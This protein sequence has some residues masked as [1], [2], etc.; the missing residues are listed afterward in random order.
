MWKKTACLVGSL[1]LSL[2]GNVPLTGLYPAPRHST[3]RQHD[4]PCHAAQLE[5]VLSC[6][7]FHNPASIADCAARLVE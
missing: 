2:A 3:P 7:L 4:T 1:H 5:V 6:G